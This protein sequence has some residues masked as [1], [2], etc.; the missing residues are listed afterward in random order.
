M[1]ALITS[2]Y[3]IKQNTLIIISKAVGEQEK[4]FET[5][6]ILFERYSAWRVQIGILVP[7]NININT[8][9][10]ARRYIFQGLHKYWSLKFKKQKTP[11]LNY[12]SYQSQPF[13]SPYF[14]RFLGWIV[15]QKKGGF[16]IRYNYN[17]PDSLDKL[18]LICGI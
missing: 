13:N 1:K 17:V 16:D 8:D 7:D 12:N 6:M 15:V 4:E 18:K 9:T 10:I 11:I 14:T 2:G 3:F 5:F